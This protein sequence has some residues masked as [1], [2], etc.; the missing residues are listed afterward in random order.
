MCMSSPVVAMTFTEETFVVGLANGLLAEFEITEI[1]SSSGI[2]KQERKVSKGKMSAGDGEISPFASVMIKQHVETASRPRLPSLDNKDMSKKPTRVY[3]LSP[4]PTVSSLSQACKSLVASSGFLFL[5]Q[6]E[7]IASCP[8]GSIG[9]GE[10]TLSTLSLKECKEEDM[11][12]AQLQTMLRDGERVT[13]AHLIMAHSWPLYVV[14]T[15]QGRII[16]VPLAPAHP[17]RCLDPGSTE[18][19]SCILY[20]RSSLISCSISGTIH[21]WSL[22]TSDLKRNSDICTSPRS[23]DSGQPID[24]EAHLPMRT[25]AIPY[26]C[27]KVMK[28]LH[29]LHEAVEGLSEEMWF[30][31]WKYWQM[32]IIGQLQ[33]ESLVL[34]SLEK[35]ADVCA[36][37]G[38]KGRL[39]EVHVHLLLD[40][41]LITNQE[42][43]CSLFNMSSL[44][45]ERVLSVTSLP[46]KAFR[47]SHA[48]SPQ[49]LSALSL[50]HQ[51]L[52]CCI[53]GFTVSHSQALVWSE[54]LV[55]GAAQFPLLC[56]NVG[57]IAQSFEEMEE[58][59]EQAEFVISMLKIW[60]KAHNDQQESLQDTLKSLFHAY[61]PSVIGTTGVFGLEESLSFRLPGHFSPWETSSHVTSLMSLSL[62]S[63]LQACAHFRPAFQ[64][65]LDRYIAS[66]M[67]SIA[68]QFPTFHRPSLILLGLEALSG[69]NVAFEL[70]KSGLLL[71]TQQEREEMLKD[72]QRLH[73]ASI[74]MY[75]ST[76]YSETEGSPLLAST[77]SGAF[78]GQI[79]GIVEGLSAVMVGLLN[80]SGVKVESMSEIGLTLLGM[81]RGNRETFTLAAE[82]LIGSG[83]KL[84]RE[85]L[86]KKLYIE[87]VVSLLF[88]HY[89]GDL[90]VRTGA[91]KALMAAGRADIGNFTRVLAAEV[92]KLAGRRDY[93][94]SVLL[95]LQSFLETHICH[96]LGVLPDFAEIIL[97]SLDTRE[98]LLRKLCVD[99]AT[100]AL[101]SMVQLYPMVAF[102]PHRQLVAVGSCSNHIFIYDLKLGTRWKDLSAHKGPVSA[103]CFNPTGDLMVSYSTSDSLVKVW[104]IGGAFFGLGSLDISEEQVIEL[105]S[106]AAEVT[107]TR[108]LLQ[109]VK[110]WWKGTREVLLSREDTQTY[111]VTLE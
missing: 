86:H 98:I 10:F 105:P 34:I 36:F 49:P 41:L 13:D 97:Q 92:R 29:S 50:S 57:L 78:A 28:H 25:F 9:A 61:T 62:F 11:A 72:W 88:L 75:E 18:A 67:S 64:P 85:E 63:V 26:E 111:L 100:E 79:V 31:K 42:G 76:E 47:Q 7:F 3:D 73:K 59:P 80:I 37:Y 55:I 58:L 99:R 14:G 71:F 45:L 95:V 17:I 19:I 2:E 109:T 56:L 8:A 43:D 12:D 77:F 27:V 110:L 74:P 23:S 60:G 46:F 87:V 53:Q 91:T 20:Y 32:M 16:V 102:Q 44:Q 94:S 93:P 101:E 39:R 103:I 1:L 83:I 107:S 106:V 22:T 35:C 5:S 54:Y 38:F 96:S 70:A 33:D 69:S 24:L 6:G 81:L 84:W 82:H 30:D 52:E 89:S 4:F 66:H 15:S 51:L 48:P 68:Q 21:I 40:Y 65:V 90:A 108:E 104:S